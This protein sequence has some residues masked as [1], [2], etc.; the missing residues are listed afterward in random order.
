VHKNY[1][2]RQLYE[3]SSHDAPRPWMALIAFDGHLIL[4][5][6]LRR[7]NEPCLDLEIFLNLEEWD[8]SLEV[9]LPVAL[10]GNVYLTPKI[11]LIAEA[12]PTLASLR[13][14]ATSAFSMRPF[15]APENQLVNA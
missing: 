6:S 12:S 14:Q 1:W 5:S 3:K 13:F 8:R 4:R 15:G 7:T 2:S 9:R 11:M 10:Y